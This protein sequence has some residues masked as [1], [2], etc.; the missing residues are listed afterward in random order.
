MDRGSYKC[1]AKII[2]LPI[3]F[4]VL[5]LGVIAGVNYVMLFVL[6]VTPISHSLLIR[7]NLIYVETHTLTNNN[8]INLDQFG[9]KLYCHPESTMSLFHPVDITIGVILSVEH[10]PPVDT[11]LVSALYYIETSLPLPQPIAVEIQHCV[12]SCDSNQLLTF[13]RANARSSPL[14][15]QKL[16]GGMFNGSAWGTIKLSKFCVIG[17]FNENVSASM[18][19]LVYL[20]T[21]PSKGGSGIY[22]VAF[23][24]SK[25]LNAIKEVIVYCFC[26][27]C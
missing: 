9:L 5:C 23:V 26:F 18:S 6:E 24:A 2:V 3:F 8:T 13:G 15:F 21:S 27:F 14:H 20:L 10:I 17:V 25:N 7:E 19:Y 11:N 12:D 22:H 16:P 1:I 4:S